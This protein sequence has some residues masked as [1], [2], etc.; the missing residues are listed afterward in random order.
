MIHLCTHSG[1]VHTRISFIS[2]S[3]GP[4]GGMIITAVVLGHFLHDTLVRSSVGSVMTS[5]GT[6]ASWSLHAVGGALVGAIM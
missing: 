2:S 3:L 4:T 6:L 5:F 1:L